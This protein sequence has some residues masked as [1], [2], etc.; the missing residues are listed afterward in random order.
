MA[1][2]SRRPD[3]YLGDLRRILLAA[4]D[5][6][7]DPLVLHTVTA[8][9]AVE[10]IPAYN[11][12]FR[13]RWSAL[14]ET[15]CRRCIRRYDR[16]PYPITTVQQLQ[17]RGLAHAHVAHRATPADH[18]VNAY[19][20]EAVRELLPLPKYDFGFVFD[21]GYY[22]TKRGDHVRDNVFRD[23]KIA[24]RYLAG[25]F[26]D[27]PQLE[28]AIRSGHITRPIWVN[29]ELTRR[30]GANARRLRRVRHAHHYVKGRAAGSYPTPPAWW[31]DL[32]ERSRTLRLLK[33]PHLG[34]G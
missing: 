14:N 11:R 21:D 17:R 33:S 24:G 18:A 28:A 22:V 12:S 32:P 1:S 30:S 19:W 7:D 20:V 23:P 5:Q 9:A 3:L 8:P 25:Y 16:R 34:A 31:D 2:R 6:L 15:A 4:F 26:V 10:N 13:R 29:P 27:S